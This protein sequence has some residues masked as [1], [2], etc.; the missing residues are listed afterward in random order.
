VRAAVAEAA[1]RC[2]EL[3][4]VAGG[5]SFGGRM[6]S[7]AQA[8]TPLA[9]VR[10]L[11]FLGFPLHPAGKP[12]EQRA[13]HLYEVGVPMLF[14]Q[15][16]RDNLAQLPLV[17]HLAQALGTKASLKLFEHADH[18]FHVPVRSGRNDRDVMRELLDVLAAW[19]TAL[20]V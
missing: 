2:P 19:I 1:Q 18:S 13:R 12:S 5:K 3:P 4:L 9:G 17:E 7:Q 20:A 16:T 10:G 6:T 14:M 15:G 8:A 11:A